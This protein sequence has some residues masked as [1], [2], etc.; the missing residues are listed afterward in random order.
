MPRLQFVPE[1]SRCLV[2][3]SSGLRRFSAR[4]FDA[5]DGTEVRLVECRSCTF[6][7]QYPPARNEQ[8][9]VDWFDAAYDGRSENASSYFDPERKRAIARLELDF[10]D[11]LPVERKTLLDLGAGAG[12]FAACAAEGGWSVTAVDPALDASRLAGN[13]LLRGVRGTIAEVPTSDRYDVITMWDVIEHAASPIELVAEA[14]RRLRPRGWIVIETGNYKSV[15]RVL[16]GTGHWIYQLDHRWYFSPD[17]IRTLLEQSGFDG[18]VL[19]DR[20]LRPGW[21]GRTRY[22]GPSRLQLLKSMLAKPQRISA[23]VSEFIALDKAKGW[24]GAGLE[25]FAIAARQA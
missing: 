4:A 16:G 15:A 17:S 9:S 11:R 8:E 12:V 23:H 14:K 20:V 7:W 25:I 1:S 18:F 3:G 22:A 5:K 6:A 13:P 10:V 24:E 21:N 19:A 2:C